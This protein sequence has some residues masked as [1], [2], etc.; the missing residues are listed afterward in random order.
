MFFYSLVFFL[1][2][3]LNKTLWQATAEHA[4]SEQISYT[5]LLGR[6]AVLRMR[7][8][9]TDQV[10]CLSVYLSVCRSVTALQKRLNR[11]RCRLGYGLG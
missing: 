8:I 10:A 3:S 2:N 5:D 1:R 7:P 6:I 11:S 4:N 9:V